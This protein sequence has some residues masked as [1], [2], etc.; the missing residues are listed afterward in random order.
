MLIFDITTAMARNSDK[1]GGK[2][3]QY[4][5]KNCKERFEPYKMYDLHPNFNSFESFSRN[6]ENK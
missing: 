5:N 3:E 2:P 6:G 1:S 4:S